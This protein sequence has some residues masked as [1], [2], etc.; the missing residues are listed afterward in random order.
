MALV[1]DSASL[2][3]IALGGFFTVV[4]AVGLVRMPEVY[5]RL[6]AVSVIDTLGAG[7]LVLGMMLQAGWSLAALKLLFILG[8][9]FFTGPVVTHA[10]ARAALH[11]GIEPLLAEDRRGDGTED[12]PAS[13]GDGRRP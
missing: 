8:L 4:G 6:H 5:T 12:G 9:F 1:L 2:V 13:P 11:E 3:L 7:L 10:L